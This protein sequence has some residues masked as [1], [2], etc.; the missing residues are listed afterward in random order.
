MSRDRVVLAAFAFWL[1]T[2]A[3]LFAELARQRALV[4]KAMGVTTGALLN[5]DVAIALAERCA[6]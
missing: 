5:T 1:L 3:L 4:D 6:R 2:V